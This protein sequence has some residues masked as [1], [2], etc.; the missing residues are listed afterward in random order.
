MK[1]ITREDAMYLKSMSNLIS[2]IASEEST[3]TYISL[4][5]QPFVKNELKLKLVTN[6]RS[7]ADIAQQLIDLANKHFTCALRSLSGKTLPPSFQRS[8]SSIELE[9][10]AYREAATHAWQ[11]HGSKEYELFQGGKQ[12]GVVSVLKLDDKNVVEGKRYKWSVYGTDHR[13]H[14]KYLYKAQNNVELYSIPKT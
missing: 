7:K 1:D 3:Q 5:A 14:E 11:K 2:G 12:V 8:L 9:E 4:V 6:G 13:G 10:E